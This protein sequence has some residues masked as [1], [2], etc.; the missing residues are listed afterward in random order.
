M[1]FFVY[2]IL[3]NVNCAIMLEQCHRSF[4]VIVACQWQFPTGSMVH[5]NHKMPAMMAHIE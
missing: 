4:S 2:E 3:C 5:D 1:N